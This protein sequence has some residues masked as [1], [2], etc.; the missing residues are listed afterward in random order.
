MNPEQLWKTTMDPE[1]RTLL[2]VSIEDA[3]EAD[4]L[5]DVLM[6]DIVEPRREFHRKKRPV[7]QESGYIDLASHYA[8]YFLF[9]HSSGPKSQRVSMS[10]KYSRK[11]GNL[12][13]IFCG[14]REASR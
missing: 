10:Y 5:F 2:S 12:R 4:H 3:A 14:H 6:G 7:R 8:F 9:S 11:C 1:T 13:Y